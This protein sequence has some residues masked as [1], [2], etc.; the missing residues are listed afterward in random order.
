MD[1]DS[2]ADELLAA[3]ALDSEH[4]YYGCIRELRTSMT[5]V[6]VE[7][8]CELLATH[9]DEGVRIAAA[10][11]L[12]TDVGDFIAARRLEGIAEAAPADERVEMVAVELGRLRMPDAVPSLRALAGHR[13][14]R[15]RE[16][17]ATGLGYL[18]EAAPAA[19]EVL[20]Y[21]SGDDAPA[22]RDRATHELAAAPIDSA[23]V[24]DALAARLDDEDDEVRFEAA[25]GLGE[26][27]DP[28]AIDA[29]VAFWTEFEDADPLVPAALELAAATGDERLRPIV[30]SLGPEWE[31]GEH[32]QTLVR[33]RRN[34]GL[35]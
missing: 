33:A 20:I 6:R 15:V 18:A 30:E 2:L 35:S 25:R 17:A 29:V 16:G 11:V 22:V 24:R 4:A 9:P 8:L 10:N 23:A 19:V 27:A 32:A 1:V 5:R 7:G 28:R 14:D 12:G 31:Y 3:V 13:A 26:R 21:L 34:L